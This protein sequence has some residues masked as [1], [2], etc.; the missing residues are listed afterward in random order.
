MKLITFVPSPAAHGAAGPRLGALVDSRQVLDLAQAAELHAGRADPRFASMLALIQA[1]EAAWDDARALL[2]EAPSAAL[3]DRARVTLRAPLPLPESIRDF[4]NYELHVRQAIRSAM[5]LRA[6]ATPD[7]AA[8]LQRFREAGMFEI[9][10][11]WFDMP[12]YYKGNRFS[13]IGHGQPV[14]WPAFAEKMDY[15]LELAV[16]I[17]KTARD[18]PP[19]RAMDAVFGY[20][21]YNDF[22]ARDM[23]AK[24][25]SFRMG[26]AKGKDFDTGNAFGPCIVTRD[27]LPDPLALAMS[28]RVNG[29]LKVST[30]SAGMQ[31]DIAACISHVS[32]SETLHPGEIF[33]MGTLGNGCGYESLSF[34]AAGDVV[35]L[36]VEGIGILRNQLMARE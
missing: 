3:L 27:E 25:T 10:Q 33:G 2:A 11:V 34:L 31:H 1:G 24:E 15:E 23:Q 5:T 30:T 12:L 4:A 17:G 36:E 13:C 35:E 16:V 14:Q 8:A 26:P 6:N 29:E 20:T 22:S 28:V 18:V 32:R 21:I 7:P 9:P 19:E